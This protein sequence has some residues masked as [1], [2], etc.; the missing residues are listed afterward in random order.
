MVQLKL[1]DEKDFDHRGYMDFVD[2]VIDKSSG[3]IRGRA[4]FS[5]PNGVLTPGM[6]GRIRVPGSPVY[7]ALL[8][9]DA[10]IGTEQTKKFVLVVDAQNKVSA[11]Y[12]TLGS[13][14]DDN[15]RVIKDGITAGDRIV[16]NGLMRTRAG[17]TVTPQEQGTPVGA[18]GPQA[19][20]P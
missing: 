15:L 16:V 18:A 4:V 12:V 10:A 7:Q 9:P 17:Q 5:N 6:F 14:H 2:N 11:K 20:N 1:L 19:K 13:L 8:V 3:T